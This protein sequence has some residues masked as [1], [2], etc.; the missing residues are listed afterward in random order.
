[1]EFNLLIDLV[2]KEVLE[3][4]NNQNIVTKLE[5]KRCLVIVNGGTANLDQVLLQLKEIS[6]DYDLKI[7]FSKS[8]KEIVGEDRFSEYEIQELSMKECSFFLQ[9]IDMI[10]VPFMTKNTCAKVAVGIRDNTIT[11][12]ISKAISS[13]K[14][15]VALEDSCVLED[16]TAYGNQIN[17]NIKKLKSYGITFLKSI[18]LSNYILRERKNRINSFREKKIITL[19]DMYNIKNSKIMLSKDTVITTLAREKA[20]DNKVVFEIEE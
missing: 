1:M 4:L 13:G 7:I 14:E 19:G 9:E 18:E 17:L 15:I 3:K 8:G 6:S 20:K 12:I 11:Y 16:G 10:L 5:K 2:V